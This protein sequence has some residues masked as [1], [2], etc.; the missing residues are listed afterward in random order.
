MN[1]EHELRQTLFPLFDTLIEG[2]ISVDDHARLDTLLDENA[3]A[4]RL[5][6]QYL[7]LDLGIQQLQLSDAQPNAIEELLRQTAQPSA[8]SRARF[9]L[10]GVMMATAVCVLIALFSYPLWQASDSSSD[11]IANSA[12][13]DPGRPR[14]ATSAGCSLHIVH[15]ININITSNQYVNYIYIK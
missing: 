5:Y 1:D 10:L 2:N 8:G 12:A 9:V 3:D 14:R 13:G 4:R 7:E 15:I 11:P 6:S